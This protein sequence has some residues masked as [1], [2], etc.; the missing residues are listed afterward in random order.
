[1]TISF[2]DKSSSNDVDSIK[3]AVKYSAVRGIMGGVCAFIIAL[4]S[5]GNLGFDLAS[6]LCGVSFGVA[7]AVDL[8]NYLFLG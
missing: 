3:L 7:I 1:M 6:I 8:I 4:L 5:G 2:F